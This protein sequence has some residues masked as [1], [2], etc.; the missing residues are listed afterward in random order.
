MII[1]KLKDDIEFLL[2]VINTTNCLFDMDVCIYMI[3]TIILEIQQILMGSQLFKFRQI[4]N[5]VIF[6][7][8]IRYHLRE[9]IE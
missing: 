9:D 3:S 4:Y 2:L 7:G 8:Y 1:L 5:E 6:R